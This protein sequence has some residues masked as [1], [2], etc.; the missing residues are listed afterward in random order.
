MHKNKKSMIGLNILWLILKG[1]MRLKF[2]LDYKIQYKS[3]LTLKM[4]SNTED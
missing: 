3:H 2:E 1:M 4:I